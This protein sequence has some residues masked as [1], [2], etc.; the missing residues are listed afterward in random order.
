MFSTCTHLRVLKLRTKTAQ[1]P[2]QMLG[3]DL[4]STRQRRHSRYEHMYIDH[5]EM[6]TLVQQ[7]NGNLMQSW[8]AAKASRGR[9]CGSCVARSTSTI[10]MVNSN[11][12]VV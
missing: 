11:I 6:T 7:G 2:V 10:S 8:T 5:A 12:S 3:S 4:I 1:E 9:T